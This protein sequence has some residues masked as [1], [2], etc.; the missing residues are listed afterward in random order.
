[1]TVTPTDL[2]LEWIRAF[3]AAGRTGSFTAAADE[4]GLTQSAISQRIA[5]LENRLGTRLFTRGA[6]GVALTVDGE[7]WLP[8][9]T[10]A[11]R[12]LQQS[13]EDLFGRGRRHLTIS[14]SASV[15]EL[16]LAP[17]LGAVGAADQLH[18]T[19]KT[20]VVADDA[21][22]G[23]SIRY[24][25][26]S[27]PTPQKVPLFAEA[28]SPVAAPGLL[29]QGA[30]WQDLPRLALSGPRPGWSEWMLATGDS[31]VPVPTL[32]LDGFA[33]SLA[34]AR[35]G[36][37]VLLASLP[38]AAADLRTGALVRLSEDVLSPRETYWLIGPERQLSPRLWAQL[39]RLFTETPDGTGG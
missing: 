23:L 39:V 20:M 25:T 21:G 17:R 7:A 14:A 2:P 29:K 24:G 36:A 33:A 28:I 37:G 1:M 3:E 22:E 16:W 31:T 8:Y 10:G 15:Q 19:L 34:A 6:R 18:L 27:W 12:T 26:G 4:T 13:S 38:L 11:L 30:R 5:H 32:R 35:A 9:V